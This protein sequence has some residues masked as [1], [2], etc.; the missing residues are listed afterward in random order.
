MCGMHA[1]LL[2]DA[3]ASNGAPASIKSFVLCARGSWRPD[4]KCAAKSCDKYPAET[5]L[6]KTGALPGAAARMRA[7][8]LS[9]G[10]LVRPEDAPHSVNAHHKSL[11]SSNSAGLAYITR[12]FL[13]NPGS[14]SHN[15]NAKNRSA[16]S[17]RSSSLT[18][19]ST[20]LSNR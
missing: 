3:A 1:A 10:M 16:S 15:G 13:E 12:T 4:A 8:N 18:L 6:S 2:H 14:N 7:S 20:S 9:N 19:A 11:H 5:T 17:R